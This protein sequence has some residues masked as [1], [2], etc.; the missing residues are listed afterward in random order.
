MIT[1]DQCLFASKVKIGTSNIGLENGECLI[2]FISIK[3]THNN[4]IQII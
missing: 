1:W 2:Y 4:K 3:Y